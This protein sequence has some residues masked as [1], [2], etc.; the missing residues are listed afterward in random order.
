MTN[1][2]IV[3]S[4]NDKIFIEKIIEVLNLKSIEIDKPICVGEDEP[5]CVDD[6]NCL[7]GLSKKSLTR[8]LQSLSDQ[9]P[10]R[11][12]AKVGIIIDQDQKTLDERLEFV[13]ECVG[14]VFEKQDSVLLTDTSSLIEIKTKSNIP[15]ELKLGCY[16]MNVNGSGELETVLKAIKTK[17]SH[18]AD[19]L[20]DW[21]DCSTRQGEV[22]S[23]KDFDKF[24]LAN[25]IRFDTCSKRESTQAEKK[26]SMRNFDYVLQNKADIFD[27]EN[28]VLEDLKTFLKLFTD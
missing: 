27:F 22:I 10:K 7:D 18:C 1:I 25:Y 11:E 17:D 16:F 3:E 5:I 23:K 20:K 12:I 2:L 8:S 9:L 4:K 28:S 24:W 19:C 21:R 13:N 26:C 15:I 14:Q 6:Y